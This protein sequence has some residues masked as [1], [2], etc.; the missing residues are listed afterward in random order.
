MS[1]DLKN[2]SIEELNSG[3]KNLKINIINIRKNK[4][5]KS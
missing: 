3:L 1:A 2:L 4:K 5:D